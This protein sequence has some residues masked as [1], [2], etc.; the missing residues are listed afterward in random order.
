V[1]VVPDLVPDEPLDPARTFVFICGPEVM[2]RYTLRPLQRQGVPD[3]RIF[4]S[5]ERNM[6]CAVA[7]CGHCQFGPV[8]VCKDG[9]VLALDRLRPWF[10]TREL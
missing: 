9:P 7:F 10:F 2:M 3:A 8:F 1:G 5:I 6:K 4:L